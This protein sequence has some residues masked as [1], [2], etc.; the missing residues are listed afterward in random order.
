LPSS[1]SGRE[2]F[3]I[4]LEGSVQVSGEENVPAIGLIHVPAGQELNTIHIETG[5][6][7][8]LKTGPNL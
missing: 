1:V 7:F 3:I 4:V 8:M 6:R 2:R 5:T